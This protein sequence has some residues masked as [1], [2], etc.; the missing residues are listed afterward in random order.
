RAAGERGEAGRRV[1]RVRRARRRLVDRVAA[2][3]ARRVRA[4]GALRR[5]GG[6]AVPRPTRAIPGA[7]SAD[8]AEP[9]RLDGVCWGGVVSDGVVGPGAVRYR[10]GPWVTRST[11]TPWSS[12][13][14][15]VRRR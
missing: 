4:A 1:P 6:A 15:T 5:V 7:G 9:V 10:A 11:S 8:R 2:G 13:S 12:A 14:V 3:N